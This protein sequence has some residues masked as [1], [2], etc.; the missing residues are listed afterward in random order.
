MNKQHHRHHALPPQIA[1]FPS[2]SIERKSTRGSVLCDDFIAH[3]Q[4]WRRSGTLVFTAC[5]TMLPKLVLNCVR[6]QKVDPRMHFF[7]WNIIPTMGQSTLMSRACPN[8]VIWQPPA[9]PNTPILMLYHTSVRGG[10]P[11]FG[12]DW[13]GESLG[14]RGGGGCYLLREI[15]I[16]EVGGGSNSWLIGL[17]F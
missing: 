11:D 1:N 14:G 13:I 7:A 8:R 5:A 4:L 16:I 9:S 15:S 2:Q 12:G 17:W 3:S 10:G 6:A